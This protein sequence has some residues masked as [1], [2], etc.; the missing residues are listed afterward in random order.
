MNR[1]DDIG[2]KEVGQG[3]QRAEKQCKRER[4]DVNVAVPAVTSDSYHTTQFLLGF[5]FCMKKV[6]DF[7]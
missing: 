1:S 3:D 2:G 6:G 4:V 7:K 5:R